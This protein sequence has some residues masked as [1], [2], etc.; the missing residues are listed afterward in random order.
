MPNIKLADGQVKHYENPIT[1]YD[2]AYSISPN[3]AKAALAG[4]VNGKLVDTCFQIQTNADVVII[5]EK[6]AESFGNYSSFH[7]PFI[8]SSS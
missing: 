7:G 4:K 8:S 5:T 1:I 3:L 2:I 6:Q